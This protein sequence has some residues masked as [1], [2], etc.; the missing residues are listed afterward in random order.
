MTVKIEDYFPRATFQKMK[1]FA[2]QHET[3]FVVID[4]ETISK[5]YDDLRAGFEFAKVYYAVKANPAVEIID[6]LRDKGSSFDIASI[7]ELDKVMSRGVG[8][9]RIS[10]GNTIKKSRDIR[11]FFEKGVRM[12]ATDS[13][14][15]LRNI[16]KAAPGAKVYVRILTEGSTTADWP[17]SRK[18]G[19]QT[20]M[21]MDL[22][23]L[24][25]QLGLEP[26]G[27]SFHVGSQQRDISV[28]DAAIAKVKVIFERLREEDGIVLKMI[29]MGGGFPA[30]YIAK[31]NDLETYAA[32]IIRF[33]KEDFGEELPEI[34][35]EPGRSLIANAGILVSEVVLVSRKSRTAVERWVYADV[36]KF[37]G[38]IETMDEAIK[39]PIWTE[40]KGEMEEVVIAGPT[41]DSA[42]IMYENY[43]YGLPLNLAAGDRLYWLSTGAYT[44]S[45]SAVE[46]NGFPPLKAYYI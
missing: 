17:L 2:D 37:S 46:F 3:P 45:Y 29:N 32:E 35:L 34:I 39:F 9:E 44:T 43:R 31:T 6:L 42:D 21:A 22:L 16:A 40:K 27:I 10:Y 1:A 36:G 14:A 20:D 38:L 19:C 26:Y 5:A 13:E 33:L 4:T 7:Y 24:A 12:F 25:R 28:W 30:N 41:C 11:Y 23:I 18:F 8:P 15:D